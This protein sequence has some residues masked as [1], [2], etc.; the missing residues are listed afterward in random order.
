MPRAPSLRS[1]F[2]AW[3]CFSLAFNTVFQAFLTTFL[4]D[5]GYKTPIQDMDELFTSGIKLAYPP[6]YNFMAENG[7]E[8]EL[9]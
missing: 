1:L 9:Q 8:T 4:I 2:F 3:V 7:D 6:E 5:S